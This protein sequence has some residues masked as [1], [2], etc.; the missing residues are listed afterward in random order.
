[1]R[2]EGELEVGRGY[3]ILSANPQSC[4]IS[5]MEIIEYSMEVED[6]W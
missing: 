2:V 4:E 1:M 3:W 6:G 5:G